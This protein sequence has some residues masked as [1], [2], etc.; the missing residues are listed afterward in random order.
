MNP[1]VGV[2]LRYDLTKHWLLLARGTVGGFIDS[3]IQ[4]DLFAGVGYQFTDW[5]MATIGYRY[6]HEEFSRN[7]FTLD[8]HLNGFLLGFAF[9][10]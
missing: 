7:D 8:A 1:L 2:N 6:L 10:F 3:N 5:C 9:H 4:F